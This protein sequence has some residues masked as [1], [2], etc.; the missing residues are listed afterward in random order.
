[1]IRPAARTARLLAAPCLLAVLLLWA[2]FAF[3][4]ESTWWIELL[5]YLPYPI[6]LAPA[7]LALLLSWRSGWRWRVASLAALALVLVGVMDLQLN[8]GDAAGGA[9]LR[10]M[11]FNAKAYQAG[12]TADGFGRIAWEIAL[13][14]AD[15]IALQD[16]NFADTPEGLPAPI[17]TALGDRQVHVSGQYLVASRHPMRD[18][19]AGDISFPGE[20]HHYVVCTITAHGV[21]FDLATAH[22]LSPREGLNATRRERLGGLG[23]WREN[24]EMR[25][26]QSRRLAQDLAAAARPLV[27]A[28]DLNAPDA[29]PVI[30]RLREAGLRDSFAAAGLGWGYSY[31]HALRTRFSFLRIDHVMVSAPIGVKDSF[32]GS[33]EA[34]AHRPVI[35]D[36]WLARR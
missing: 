11:S 26:I 10:V 25:M 32:V 17:K 19:R 20:G 27:L 2:A 12:N 13:H 7:L 30:A 3:G 36:L 14:D 24:F 31:G 22:L 9:P 16:A 6:F 34:S 28:G 35:A 23:E 15:V 33:A 18:C 1:M 5:R 8:R 4:T 21:E 29:S